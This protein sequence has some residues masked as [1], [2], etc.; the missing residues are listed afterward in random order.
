MEADGDWKYVLVG[1]ERM[2]TANGGRMIMMTMMMMLIMI[3]M[4]V[5]MMIVMMIVMMMLLKLMRMIMLLMI[6][7]TDRTID[8]TLHHIPLL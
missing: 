2:L 1:N 5:V 3:K 7:V 6:E 4:M 8:T